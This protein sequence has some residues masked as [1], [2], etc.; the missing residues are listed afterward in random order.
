MI[1]FCFL[2]IEINGGYSE[3]SKYSTCSASCGEGEQIR[4]RACINPIPKNGGDGCEV[5]GAATES[6]PC[7]IKECP[8]TFSN[9]YYVFVFYVCF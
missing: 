4:E 2:L 5:L 8:S 7:K 1:L 9:V 3:W 6:R